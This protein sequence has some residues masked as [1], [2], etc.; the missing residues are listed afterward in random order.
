MALVISSI[1]YSGGRGRGILGL[2]LSRKFRKPGEDAGELGKDNVKHTPELCL[3][4]IN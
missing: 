1:A 4:H 3:G 2:D